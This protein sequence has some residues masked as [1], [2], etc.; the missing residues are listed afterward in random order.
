MS[1]QKAEIAKAMDIISR[2]GLRGVVE[3][4]FHPVLLPLYV[5]PAW[6]RSL[7]A[8]RILLWGQWSKYHGFHAHNALNCLTYRT[9][10]ININRYGRISKSHT[11]GLGGY[12]IAN[13][14]HLSSIASYIYANAGAV[15]TLLCTIF[16]VSGHLL[17]LQATSWKWV[18]ILTTILM[19]STTSYFMAFARQNYQMLSWMWLPIALYGLLNGE[20][21]IAIF[22]FFAAALMGITAL[23]VSV[24]MVIAL[25]LQ[26]DNLYMLLVLLP[27]LAV[28]VFKFMPVIKTGGLR[29]S[30]FMI[31]KAVGFVHFNA[32]LKRKA[33]RF[34]LFNLYFLLLYG[35]SLSLIWSGSERVPVLLLVAYLLFL[36]NQRFMRFADEESVIMVF[37][38]V[39][40]SYALMAPASVVVVF[41]LI[42][43]VSPLP[44]VLSWPKPKASG[45]FLRLIDYSP[46]DITNLYEA[47]QKFLSVPQG[48]RILFAFNDPIDE[49]EKIFD[50]QRFL[51]E[52]PL[53]VASEKQIHL[54]PDWYAVSETNYPEAPSIWGRDP[55]AVERNAKYWGAQYVIVYQE[56]G[57]L[58][59]QWNEKFDLV[60]VFSWKDWEAELRGDVLWYGYSKPPVW[61]LLKVK[62]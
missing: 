1:E 59:S 13:W 33:M 14:W 2:L 35:I 50:G 9:Q 6:I 36:M 15:T 12:S 48:A 20:M 30:L 10:W 58:E 19:F 22:A 44:I 25:A 32:R 8:S 61:F 46:F 53:V 38:T 4:L 17:W 16:W 56:A 52:L 26:K 47:I 45:S 34:N 57:D 5:F 3:L 54:F 7:W 60:S 27:A 24:F 37:V 23:F 51:I 42:A 39:A 21:V 41:G 31:S 43:A 62:T 18:L 55:V 11:L 49:Y 28:T 29:S 40:M